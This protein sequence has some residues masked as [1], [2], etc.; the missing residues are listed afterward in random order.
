[1]LNKENAQLLERKVLERLDK[2]LP[3]NERLSKSI[4]QFAVRASILTLQEY[5]RMT[6]DQES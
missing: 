1:M 4:M 3:E 2:L 5:E 6:E